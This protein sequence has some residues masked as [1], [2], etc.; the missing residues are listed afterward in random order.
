[1]EIKRR[2]SYTWVVDSNGYRRIDL[3]LGRMASVAASLFDVTETDDDPVRRRR[4]DG[5][6]GLVRFDSQSQR[7]NVH[8]VSCTEAERLPLSA[9]KRSWVVCRPVSS[10]FVLEGHGSSS[11]HPTEVV[12]EKVLQALRPRTQPINE[13]IGQ[14][15]EAE[16]QAEVERKFREAV[17]NW[18][19]DT[20]LQSSSTRRVMNLSY[21][22]IIKMGEEVV[23][24]LLQELRDR[25]NQWFWALKA[26]T[27]EDPTTPGS[28]FQ[29]MVDAWLQWGEQHG[30][31]S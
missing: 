1:M 4:K 14:T 9:W 8:R 22:K 26:I 3:G 28:S 30:Y 31:N 2:V 25:P 23:P 24:L 5:R 10:T 13:F 15:E 17:E 18:Y 7:L 21:Q 6:P 27:E 19:R 16:H 29:E 12:E 20:R 11:E